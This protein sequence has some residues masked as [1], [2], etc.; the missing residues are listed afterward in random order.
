MCVWVCVKEREAEGEGDE[1][2]SG[3]NDGG[4]KAEFVNVII[5]PFTAPATE[6]KKMQPRWDFW[7]IKV[8]WN[9]CLMY[10]VSCFA[11]LLHAQNSIKEKKLY[12]SLFKSLVPIPVFFLNDYFSPILILAELWAHK[13]F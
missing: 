11:I 5:S 13:Q 6:T 9:L 4:G 12:S 2:R 8:S 3:E 7:E 10:S 1:W